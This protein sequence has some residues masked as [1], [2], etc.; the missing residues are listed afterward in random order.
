M[1]QG[2]CKNVAETFRERGNDDEV[3]CRKHPDGVID[4]A[5]KMHMGLQA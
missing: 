4:P 3:C 1:D 2:F 5:E